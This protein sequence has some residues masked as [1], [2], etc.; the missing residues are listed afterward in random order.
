MD[1]SVIIV[2]WNTRCLLLQCLRSL[3]ESIAAL[4]FEIVVIDNG[5]EDGSADKVERLFPAVQLVR[6]AANVGFAAANN[7]GIRLSRGS[8]LVL[9]NSDTIVSPGALE[10]MVSFMRGHSDVGA[11]GC[12]LLNADGSPQ[13]SFADFPTLWSALRGSDFRQHVYPLDEDDALQVDAVSGACLMVRREVIDRVGGLDESFALFG[14]EMD[15][16]YRIQSAGWRVCSLPRAQ[17]VHLLGQS[18]SRLPVYSYVNLHRSRVLFFTKHYGVSSARTLRIGYVLI[19]LSKIA[20]A[21]L[22][23]T[24]CRSSRALRADRNRALLGCLVHGH[25]L[26]CATA[27]VP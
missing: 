17:V 20:L 25:C 15:W 22:P 24:G 6:N 27:E 12:Q 21:A 14:E 9:L 5:S 3:Y 7:D 19:A 26:D 11:L 8:H 1:L 18:R 10:T 16:C 23:H 2:N 4:T 13:D